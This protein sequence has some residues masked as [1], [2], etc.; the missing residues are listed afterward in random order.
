MKTKLDEM[1]G[2]LRKEKTKNKSEL[3]PV[4]KEK[5]PET[6]FYGQFI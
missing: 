3:K 2:F 6:S 1:L 5:S 4:V